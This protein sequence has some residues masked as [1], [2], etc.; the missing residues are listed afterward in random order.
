MTEQRP[1]RLLAH[2]ELRLFGEQFSI[3][4]LRSMARFAEEEIW[5]PP[6]GPFGEMRFELDRQ[7]FSRSWFEE[8]DSGRWQEHF[9]AA[10]SQ[11]GKTTICWVIPI[12]YHLFEVQENVIAGLPDMN[13]AHDK[14]SDDLLPVIRASRYRDQLPIS[15]VG[16]KGGAK[17]QAITFR[18][19]RT[20]RFMSAA[21]SDK[22][23][24]GK[25]ARVIAITELGAFGDVQ[26]SSSESNPYNQLLARCEAFD[27]RKVIYGECTVTT[28]ANIVWSKYQSGSASKI[29]VQCR[30]C[31][32]WVCPERNHLAGYHEAQNEIDAGLAATFFCPNCGGFWSPEDRQAMN[33]NH[34]LLHK[35]QTIDAQ[36]HISGEP[37]KTRRLGFRWNAFN[38]LFKTPA[39]LAEREW[40]AMSTASEVDEI[41]LRQFVW[42]MPTEPTE[43]ESIPLDRQAVEAK[44]VSLLPRGLAPA[45]TEFLVAGCDV[46]DHLLHW[47]VAATLNLG[48]NHWST[49]VVNYGLIEVPSRELGIERGLEIAFQQLRDFMEAGFTVEQR[50]EAWAPWQVF[51]DSNWRPDAVHRLCRLFGNRY[52]ATQGRGKGQL[53]SEDY[54]APTAT[55]KN[56][57]ELGPRWHVSHQPERGVDLLQ[58]DTNRFKSAV[59]DGL[60]I[61]VGQPGS[62]TVFQAGW[63]EHLKF[64][65]HLIAE[66]EVVTFDPR[67]G[68]TT[69]WQRV[70]EKA[71][72]WL[73]STALCMVA[74]SFCLQ[75]LEK[76]RQQQTANQSAPPAA[77]SLMSPAGGSLGFD[78]RRV[79]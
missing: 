53:V 71:N 14:W 49:H 5:L 41:A 64:S 51:I 26:E 66:K 6:T 58:F 57:I 76:Q 12:M 32:E 36:G 22:S 25:T 38:N 34:R 77:R 72:H 54:V 29:V 4:E 30:H 75:Q 11:S 79:T 67:K 18:N 44:I 43:F 74:Q 78:L 1:R 37:P 47:T 7:P 2:E 35:G 21:G 31:S 3:R 70:G 52:R 45:A 56:I 27:N 13:M 63:K 10:P 55:S 17:F 20:L 19:G 40:N 39:S 15:G 24:A 16:S 61:P 65:H 23:K 50:G 42:A 33:R 28:K 59:H 68:M 73:D 46:G 62:F 69:E 9:A 8:I 60:R 48:P